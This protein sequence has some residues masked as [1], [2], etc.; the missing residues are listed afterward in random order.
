MSNS[1]QSGLVTTL[2]VISLVFGIIGLLGSFI[3][4]LGAFALFISGPSLVIGVVAFFVAKSKEVGIGLSVAAST[5]SAIGLVISLMQGAALTS[6]ASETT[7]ELMAMQE[8]AEQIN[9]SLPSTVD[10]LAQKNDSLPQM[11]DSLAQ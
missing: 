6:V 2:A 1:N 8:Q 9:D 5:I 7:K 10:S 3:P 11:D 4:C